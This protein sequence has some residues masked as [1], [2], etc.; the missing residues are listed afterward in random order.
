MV[1]LHNIFYGWRHVA[2]LWVIVLFLLYC[3]HFIPML[4]GTPSDTAWDGVVVPRHDPA[5]FHQHSMEDVEPYG[6]DVP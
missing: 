2:A 3:L 4:H 1:L 5:A 6:V